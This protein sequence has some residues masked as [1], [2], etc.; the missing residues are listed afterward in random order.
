MVKPVGKPD[1]LCYESGYVVKYSGLPIFIEGNAKFS[2]H[3]SMSPP[4][5]KDPRKD[6]RSLSTCHFGKHSV[7]GSCALTAHVSS[8]LAFISKSTSA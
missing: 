7:N 6:I 5:Y 1:A 2:Q 8:A 4:F 3:N